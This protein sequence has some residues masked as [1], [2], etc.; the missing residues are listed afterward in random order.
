MQFHRLA[1]LIL[2][3]WLGIGA[4]MD[5]VAT[6]NFEMVGRVLISTD[7]RA[8]DAAKKLGDPDAPRMLLRYFA[9]EANR[10]LFEQWEWT[11]LMLGLLLLVVLVLCRSSQKLAIALCLV[12]ICVV[13]G[14]RFGLTPAIVKLGRELEFS[15][16]AS[17]RFAV[18]HAVYGYSEIGKL[19]LGL[20]MAVRLLIRPRAGKRAFAEEFESSPRRVAGGR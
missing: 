2:G 5:Y 16:T 6:Q 10:S 7:V 1:T 3:I 20:I 18:Y 15:T 13:A 4:F 12:M 9:G 14:Q 11:E 17:R 8:I 19:A